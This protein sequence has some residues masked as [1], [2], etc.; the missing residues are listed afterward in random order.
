MKL[1]FLNC[2]NNSK[3]ANTREQVSKHNTERDCWIIVD[4]LV[5]NVSDFMHEHPGGFKVLIKSGGKDVSKEFH[6]LQ[7]NCLRKIV[8]LVG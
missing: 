3:N 4:D 6:M 7:Y 2:S 1:N 8:S 5:L